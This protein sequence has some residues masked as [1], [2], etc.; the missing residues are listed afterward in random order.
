MG[1]ATYLR[2]STKPIDQAPLAAARA[3]LGEER[4]RQQVLAGGYRLHDW[5]GA[6]DV[7]KEYLVHIAAA[8]AMIPEAL[9]AAAD[10]GGWKGFRP[11]CSTSPARAG[12]MRPGRPV[13][14][15]LPEREPGRPG[16]S[17]QL[18]YPPQRAPRPADHRQ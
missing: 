13:T 2:L 17:V 6:E 12:F 18:A 15:G 5:R 1:R 16:Q 7:Y 3:R 4:L 14:K 11:M 9:A 10:A 8:G